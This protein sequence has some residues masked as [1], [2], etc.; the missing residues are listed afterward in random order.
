M[1][2]PRIRRISDVVKEIHD[3]YP[4]SPITRHMIEY[5]IYNKEITAM[6]YG[7]AWLVNIDE[8]YGYFTSNPPKARKRILPKRKKMM[9][10][11]QIFRY[12]KEA[13][14]CTII[15]KPNLRRFC[16]ANNI[17]SVK[18]DY[19]Q[20]PLYDFNDF[21]MKVNP[22]GINQIM[23]IPNVMILVQAVNEFQA[24]HPDDIELIDRGFI[25]VVRAKGGFFITRRLRILYLNY[26][27]FEKVGE[28]LIRFIYDHRNQDEEESFKTKDNTKK[29]QNL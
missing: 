12:F 6:K 5:L 4:M 27:E 7:D 23:P 9:T 25:D 18:E 16:A 2:V 22:K 19:L 11:G 3:E 17:H 29:L 24:R 21:L 13:D 20:N 1:Y 15:R 26:D 28:T 14:E 10:S 8:L